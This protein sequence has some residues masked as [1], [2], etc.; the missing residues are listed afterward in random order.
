MYNLPDDLATQGDAC[1]EYARNV[2]HERPEIAWICTPYDTWM[3]NPAYSGPPVPHPESEVSP[4]A[5][6]FQ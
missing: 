5:E 6:L 1:R 3:R 2:G 4:P